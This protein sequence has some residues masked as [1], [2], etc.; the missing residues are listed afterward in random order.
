M[1]ITPFR[2]RVIAVLGAK[3]RDAHAVSI[4]ELCEALNRPLGLVTNTINELHGNTIVT[5]TGP[6]VKLTKK[7]VDI[8]IAMATPLMGIRDGDV[9]RTRTTRSILRGENG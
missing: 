1:N 4:L 9:A 8:W 2:V 3:L 6:T 7:G 5:R